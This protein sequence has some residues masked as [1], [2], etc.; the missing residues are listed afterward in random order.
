MSNFMRNFFLASVFLA[1]LALAV[2]VH[3]VSGPDL[4]LKA[5]NIRFNKE[6]LYTGDTVRIYATIKNIGDTDAVA[7]VFFYQ[8][9]ILIGSSQAV[10]VV[11][12][13]AGDDVFVDFTVPKGAFNIRAV[14]QG[15]DP[16]DI[17]S[18]NDVAT[19]PL[20]E[21]KVDADRDGVGDDTD[22]CP[23]DANTDQLDTDHDGKGN[24]CDSDDDND[25]LSDSDEARKGTS[26]TLSDTDGDGV[27]DGAD[28]YP[29]D[30]TRSKKPVAPAPAPVVK[31]EPAKTPAPPPAAIVKAAPAATEK[32]AEPSAPITIAVAEAPGDDAPL[33]LGATKA[34]PSARFTY[35]QIDWRTY[36]FEATPP[37]G[38]GG[39]TYGWDFGDGA[40]S[41]QAKIT[42]A[43]PRAG[44]YTVTLGIVDAD[45]NV[46]SDA[47]VLDISFFHLDNPLVQLTLGLL[48]VILLGLLVF[49]IRLRRHEV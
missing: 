23:A 30:A 27:S 46:K 26:P 1:S 14:I 4:S 19:T 16:Q 12:D 8:G 48:L 40:T 13:G 39:L 10:S 31:S 28:E 32:P 17:N 11:A 47:Q 42:H 44:D 36:E 35:K 24:V 33:V 22:N 9:A 5:A 34:S 20:Y 2:N 15:S 45:G 21:P 7:Q 3:A 43:F 38:Q 49:L 37:E 25:G 6:V 18:S 29:T 41:V